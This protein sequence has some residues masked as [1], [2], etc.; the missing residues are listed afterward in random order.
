MKAS[1]LISFFLGVV[2]P[3]YGLFDWIGRH[4]GKLLKRLYIKSEQD[5]I[6]YLHYKKHAA[7]QSHDPKH[8]KDCQDDD[9]KKV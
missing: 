1:D 8:P 4:F 3:T 5:A 2:L 7:R 9:C 6:Y